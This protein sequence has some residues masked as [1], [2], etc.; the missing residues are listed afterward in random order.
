MDID[1]ARQMVRVD[2]AVSRELQAVL[3]AL[4]ARCPP[5][6]YR[7]LARDIAAAV[8]SVGAALIRKAIEAHPELEAE[9][10]ASI[11]QYGQYRE[12]SGDLTGG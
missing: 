11:K 12:P 7:K 5:E 6:E 9:I 8:D 4:K 10:D 3:Q 1:L 2:F